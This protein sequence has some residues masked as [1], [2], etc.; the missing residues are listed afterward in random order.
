MEIGRNTIEYLKRLNS[1]KWLSLRDKP[2]EVRDI[3]NVNNDKIQGA[4][5]VWL[6]I[7]NPQELELTPFYTISKYENPEIFEMRLVVKKLKIFNKK[8]ASKDSP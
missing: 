6:E 8:W 7:L 5:K 2:I 4:I 1:P 3:K